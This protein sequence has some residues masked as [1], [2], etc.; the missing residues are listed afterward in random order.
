[1]GLAER[2]CGGRIAVILEGGYDLKVLALGVADTCRALLGDDAPGED[3]I[4]LSHWQ[5]P[6]LDRL[7]AGLRKVHGL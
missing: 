7:I 1:M 5:E 2:L 6:P 3:H 4:G